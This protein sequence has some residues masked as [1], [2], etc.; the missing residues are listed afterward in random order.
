MDA[1]EWQ[2]NESINFLSHCHHFHS[3]T[4]SKIT[5]WVKENAAFVEALNV[6]FEY[7]FTFPSKSIIEMSNVISHHHHQHC[8]RCRR[9]YWPQLSRAAQFKMEE[10]EKLLL[11]VNFT[12]L[13]ISCDKWGGGDVEWEIERKRKQIISHNLLSPKQFY[14]NLFNFFLPTARMKEHWCHTLSLSLV[15]CCLW[16]IWIIESLWETRVR[17]DPSLID[18]PESQAED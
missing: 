9:K 6:P 16:Q 5:G 13:T 2:L 7:S 8:R 15:L 11:R 3:Y 1:I 14:E 18:F 17:A 10:R 4:A 12:C